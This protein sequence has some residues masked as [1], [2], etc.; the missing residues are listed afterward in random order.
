MRFALT[1]SDIR[2][3]VSHHIDLSCVT[4][5]NTAKVIQSFRHKGLKRLYEK[6]DKR[7]VGANLLSR[8]EDILTLLDVAEKP[9]DMRLPGLRLHPLTGDRKGEWSVSVSGN[10][11]VTFKFEKGNVTRVDLEDYH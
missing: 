8:V 9:E 3:Q 5:H 7:G 2:S 4:L 6:G 11:R 10:W 1:L